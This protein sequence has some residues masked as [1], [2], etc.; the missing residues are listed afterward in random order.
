LVVDVLDTVE[1]SASIRHAMYILLQY[2]KQGGFEA[3]V[4]E[5][6]RKYLPSS[7]APVKARLAEDMFARV[8]FVELVSLFTGSRKLPQDCKQYSA[9]F[10]E[11]LG[12]FIWDISP[13]V[14]FEAIHRLTLL[15][16]SRLES[17]KLTSRIDSVEVS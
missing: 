10:T 2:A 8:Y 15:G 7:S 3:Q 11:A 5:N 13:R 1:F 6:L 4:A 14:A 17:I 12:H 9:E 16:W